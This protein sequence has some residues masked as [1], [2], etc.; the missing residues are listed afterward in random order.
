MAL[1]GG[2]GVDAVRYTCVNCPLGPVFLA[3]SERGLCYLSLTARDEQEFLDELATSWR[4]RPVRAVRDDGGRA[5]WEGVLA[6]W[7]RGEPVKV[8]LD[9]AR[10]TEFERRVLEVVQ[11]IPR[12]ETRT[13]AEVARLAGRPGAARAVGRVMAKNPV[14]LLVPCHRV[15]RSDGRLGDYSG[16][17][18]SMKRRLLELEGLAIR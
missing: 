10:L 14:P 5:E 6:A 3:F 12:S 13:Y 2:S 1:A 4:G 16:G 8:E 15:V 9:L 17:G 18:P 11:G 7:F